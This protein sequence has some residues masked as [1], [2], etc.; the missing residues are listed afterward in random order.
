MDDQYKNSLAQM[1]WRLTLVDKLG[2]PQAGTGI[3][4]YKFSPYSS[5]RTPSNQTCR[6]HG[7]MAS[8]PG[9]ISLA[10]PPTS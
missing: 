2:V 5:H 10:C 9:L 8:L 4:I 6:L 7:T 3:P 1:H